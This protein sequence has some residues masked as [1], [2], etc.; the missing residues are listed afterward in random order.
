MSEALGEEIKPKEIRLNMPAKGLASWVT[1]RQVFRAL[2]NGVGFR[3]SIDGAE[4]AQSL[5][6]GEIRF[7]IR[8]GSG[9]GGGG[10]HPFKVSAA[11]G[12][13]T[14]SA[15][16]VNGILFEEDDI[17]LGGSYTGYLG[18]QCDC[19]LDINSEDWV[20][21]GSLSAI[22]LVNNGSS[23]VDDGDSGVFYLTLAH[24]SSGEITQL[25]RNNATLVVSD[26]G[27]S[28]GTARGVFFAAP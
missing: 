1:L 2:A 21:G 9:G 14:V 26:N 13:F 28:E 10:D 8:P 6:P 19:A 12:V 20:I 4:E 15:G 16:T 23:F 18:L 24:I 17:T 5:G 3:L 7:K 25:A 22:S 11:A 27:E